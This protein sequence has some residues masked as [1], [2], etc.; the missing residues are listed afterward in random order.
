MAGAAGLSFAAV[1]ASGETPA[2]APATGSPD[3]PV[4]VDS[5]SDV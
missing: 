2:D 5:T 4:A 3:A 1:S